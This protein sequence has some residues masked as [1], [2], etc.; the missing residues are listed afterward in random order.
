MS[1]LRTFLTAICV[2]AVFIGALHLIC[3]DG[4]MAKP[5]KYILSL[6]FLVSI[7]SA[8]GLLKG[9]LNTD[10]S[11]N[12]AAETSDEKLNS[13][14]ARYVYE[15]ALKNSEINFTEIT[16]CTDKMPD[17]SIV[18]SKVIIYSDCSKEIISAALGTVAENTEV[19]I[20]NE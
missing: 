12:T 18:I 10:I 17:G 7:I 5:V 19:E 3:P 13:A 8:A 11:F 9:E 1:G 20:I 4:N 14:S 16:V 6:V 2:S 15:Q